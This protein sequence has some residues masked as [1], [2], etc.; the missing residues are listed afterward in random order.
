MENL[1]TP[2]KIRLFSGNYFDPFDPDPELIL[3][4]D[5]A[6][7]L[8]MKCRFGGHTKRFYSVAEHSVNVGLLCGYQG[9]MHDASDAYLP[10]IPTP[11]K[12][13]MPEFKEIE[14]R[15]MAMIAKKFDFEWPESA[16]TKECDIAVLKNEWETAVLKEDY[17]ALLPDAAEKAFL[18]FYFMR[19]NVKRTKTIVVNSKIT[20]W[21]SGVISY[22]QLIDI[23]FP[24]IHK[25]RNPIADVM[26]YRG[27]EFNSEG[28]LR[29]GR[30]L[31]IK[32]GMV[33][34]I[35]QTN[36]A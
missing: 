4:E 17:F 12:Q 1:F 3:I 5:I 23:A 21:D 13:R 9:L 20:Q 15:L 19:G 26:F 32:D 7:G 14:N 10:D 8:S 16:K 35:A 22:D 18:E 30:H 27:P 28:I 33:F 29:A 25:S 31:K 2:N 36:N 11:I 6:H 24:G 34:N